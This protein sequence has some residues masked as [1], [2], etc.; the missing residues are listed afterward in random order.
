MS[1]SAA[2]PGVL[3][4]F[5]GALPATEPLAFE[6]S[7]TGVL[8]LHGYTGSPWEVRP[9]AEHLVA[10]G[11]TVAMPVLAGH[12]RGTDALAKTT[13][14]DWLGSAQDALDWLTPRCEQVHVVGLS[15]GALLAWLLTSRQPVLRS[16]V[17]LAPALQLSWPGGPV[18]R[19][20][21]LLR[22]P[23]HL[24][25]RP[26]DLPGELNPPP[27]GAIPIAATCSLLDLMEVV[28]G[29]DPRADVRMSAIHGT[30][31]KTI[32]FRS[33]R[34]ILRQSLGKRCRLVTIEG[35]CHLLARGPDTARILELIDQSLDA[36]EG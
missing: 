4:P 7:S 24:P 30:A 17:M 12:G 23:W 1:E 19:A 14:P 16:A 33:A 10:R 15:M 29:C 28:R 25:R 21:E 13:W 5:D 9:V 31:D 22:W 36:S 8:V 26:S 2:L 20:L 11:M 18:L 27:Y 6:G 3:I 35:G 34:R 32:P